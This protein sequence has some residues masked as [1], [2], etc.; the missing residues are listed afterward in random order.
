MLF[1]AGPE[2][3]VTFFP[4]SNVE[5]NERRSADQD[6]LNSFISVID[7]TGS[8]NRRCTQYH[9]V[10]KDHCT[11]YAHA[12]LYQLLITSCVSPST[13]LSGIL[14]LIVIQI[15]KSNLCLDTVWKSFVKQYVRSYC[16]CESKIVFFYLFRYLYNIY[17]IHSVH[18]RI[19]GF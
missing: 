9:R 16:K 7:S 5:C 1:H 4:S 14:L 11:Q 6:H 12:F 2:K 18:K 19:F 8:S 17:N 13:K 10:R 15:G 3:S